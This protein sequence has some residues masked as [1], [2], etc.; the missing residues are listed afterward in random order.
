[1]VPVNLVAEI[2]TVG[3]DYGMSA[4]EVARGVVDGHQVLWTVSRELPTSAAP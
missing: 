1:M 3:F 2:M 4:A